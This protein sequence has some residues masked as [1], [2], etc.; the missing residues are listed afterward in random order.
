[1]IFKN[2]TG[3]EERNGIH[4]DWK[5]GQWQALLNAVVELWVS[6]RQGIL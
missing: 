5:R 1:M 3:V 6:Q 4:L 2:G